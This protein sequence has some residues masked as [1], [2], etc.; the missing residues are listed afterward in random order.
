ME[1]ENFNLREEIS[2]LKNIIMENYAHM[3]K[4]VN[5][6]AQMDDLLTRYHTANLEMKKKLR[7]TDGNFENVEIIE[8]AEAIVENFESEIFTIGLPHNESSNLGYTVDKYEER[9]YKC[10]YCDK[11]FKAS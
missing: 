8:N 2:S 3:N 6:I 10:N 1:A 5:I 9:R 4:Y 11:R 7:I